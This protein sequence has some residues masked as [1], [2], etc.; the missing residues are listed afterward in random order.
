MERFVTNVNCNKQIACGV[1]VKGYISKLYFRIDTLV[2]M[3]Y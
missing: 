2:L 3:N 1:P